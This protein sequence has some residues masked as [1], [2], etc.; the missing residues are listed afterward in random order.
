MQISLGRHPDRSAECLWP[1]QPGC[2]PN[3]A[4]DEQGLFGHGVE[5][6]LVFR[7][8]SN[9]KDSP[10]RSAK[11]R[12]LGMTSFGGIQQLGNGSKGFFHIVSC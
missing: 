7:R 8:E 6:S 9:T 3:I 1:E 5:G 4:L 10:A 11:L 2:I 12:S